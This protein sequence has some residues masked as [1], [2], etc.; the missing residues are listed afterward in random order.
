M[1]YALKIMSIEEEPNDIRKFILPKPTN[2]KFIPGQLVNIAINKP[3]LEENK[4]L[5]PFFSLNNEF[6]I[7][8]IFKEDTTKADNKPFFDLKA[9]EE[10][11][12][13]DIIGDI[14]YKG[15]GAFIAA[16]KGVF[17]FIN[18]FK[19]LK[20]V[21]TL[22]GCTLIYF[23]KDNYEV[24]YERVIK[25][26]LGNNVTI[27]LGKNPFNSTQV[28]T[29]DES[30]LKQKLPSLKQE[31]YVAGPRYFVASCLEVLENLGINAQSQIIE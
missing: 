10:I 4:R 12:L 3:G 23:A 31:F 6:Y 25:H 5:C 20:A 28:K 15:K 16:G 17:P 8:V 11:I 24:Y 2:Y 14:Q 18:I 19:H 27:M 21:D 1:D 30:T 26:L 7:E 9:G 22:S 13:S 29:I